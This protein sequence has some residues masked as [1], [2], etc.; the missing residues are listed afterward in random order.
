MKNPIIIAATLLMLGCS[1]D[2]S[3][4]ENQIQ[5]IDLSTIVQ[6]ETARAAAQYDTQSKGIYRGVVATEDISYHGELTINLGNDGNYNAILQLVNGRSMGFVL[7]NQVAKDINVY[8]LK[9]RNSSFTIDVNEPQNPIIRNL[10]IAGIA[11]D[12]R[13]LKE[14][15]ASMVEVRMGSYQDS[16]NANHFGTWDLISNSS[17]ILPLG[18]PIGNFEIV[19]NELSSLVVMK[20]GGGTYMDTNIELFDPA[21]YPGCSP[22]EGFSLPLGERLPF[23]TN[24]ETLSIPIPFP[25]FVY[26]VPIHEFTIPDQTSQFGAITVN[27]NFSFSKGAGN[28][29]YDNICE[30]ATS[31]T[32]STATGSIGTAL[33]E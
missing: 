3:L 5:E 30:E 13:V 17:T 4:E 20:N 15:S 6:P 32:W 7:Q 19:V 27:W 10:T 33:L 29:Y 28:V 25:P 2:T 31:A 23:F 14:N 26:E 16:N 1:Q 22:D 18:T 11:G 9:N 8:T 12:A 24:D 21:D